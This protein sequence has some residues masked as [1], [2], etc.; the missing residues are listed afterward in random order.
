MAKWE[1]FS[2][3]KSPYPGTNPTILVQMLEKGERFP[4][5]YNGACSDEICA[6][7]AW[8]IGL[9]TS[10]G[11]GSRI[12]H[13]KLFGLSLSHTQNLCMTGLALQI[14]VSKS[15]QELL[16]STGLFHFE[17]CPDYTMWSAR[18]PIESFWLVGREGMELTLPSL[19]LAL[20]LTE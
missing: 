20:P 14:R 17:R 16:A 12:P 5:P 2:G 11:S 13:Y 6:S 10:G 15:C 18:R 9:Q 3:G 7:S 19:D 8:I 4:K 1:I